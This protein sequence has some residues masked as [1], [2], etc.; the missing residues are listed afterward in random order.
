MD[1]EARRNMWTVIEQV[2]AQRSVVLVT[3]SMEEVEA[4]CTRMGVMVSGRLQ[5]IGSAQHLKGRF[6]LGYQVEMRSIPAQV[7]ASIALCERVMSQVVVEEV[8]GGYVSLKVSKEVD[9]AQAFS[10]LE[11]HK[12][13]LNILDYSIS[14]CTLEQVFLKFAKDQEE[15]TGKVAGLNSSGPES[16]DQVQRGGDHAVQPS[17]PPEVSAVAAHDFADIYAHSEDVQAVDNSSLVRR[18]PSPGGQEDAEEKVNEAG[19]AK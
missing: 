14:Q 1:P 10:A 5:C 3:H 2:S 19:D 17:P 16:T 6:G 15:E 12:A 9:L 11:A 7:Q 8:H 18:F 13:A 4:L